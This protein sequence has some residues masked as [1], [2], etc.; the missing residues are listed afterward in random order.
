M[1][2]DIL[3]ERLNLKCSVPQK[4]VGGL[5]FNESSLDRMT[6]LKG[7]LFNLKGLKWISSFIFM[8]FR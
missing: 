3:L 1:Y 2:N 5:S 8:N 6:L 4:H 7:P